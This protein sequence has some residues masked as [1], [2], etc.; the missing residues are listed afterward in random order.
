MTE[1]NEINAHLARLKDG[2]ILLSYGNRVAEHQGVMAKLSSDEGKS[3]SAPIRL[4]HT[5]GGDCGYPSSV[6]RTD[7]QVVTAF[8]ARSAVNHE[9]Y[10]MGVVIWEAPAK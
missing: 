3:W 4:A 7:G 6:Q 8:Y 5:I 9:R 10:H 1:R 2:R